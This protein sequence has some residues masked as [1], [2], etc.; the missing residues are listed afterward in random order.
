MI[1]FKD[2]FSS[3]S[4]YPDSKYYLEQE[5]TPK[6]TPLSEDQISNM[7]E[8]FEW[9]NTYWFIAERTNSRLAMIGFMAVIINYTLFGWIAYPIL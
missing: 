6:E 4:Y 5:N 1:D 7:K 9:P 2:G 8:I 3:E